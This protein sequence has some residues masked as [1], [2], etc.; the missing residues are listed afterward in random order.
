MNQFTPYLEVI[1]FKIKNWQQG[2]A[3]YSN[4]KISLSS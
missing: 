2:K 4:S 1:D 3:A